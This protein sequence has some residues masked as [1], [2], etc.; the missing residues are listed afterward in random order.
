MMRSHGKAQSIYFPV[1][2]TIEKSQINRSRDRPVC[3]GIRQFVVFAIHKGVAAHL[4]YNQGI[5]NMQ[6]IMVS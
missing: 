1:M 4:R 6:S 3:P 5:T 2:G